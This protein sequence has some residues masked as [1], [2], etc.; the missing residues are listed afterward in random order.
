VVYPNPANDILNIKAD[1]KGAAS[2]QGTIYNNLGAVL[3]DLNF[4][5]INGV[6]TQQVAIGDLAPGMYVV[7]LQSEEGVATK[8]FVKK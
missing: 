2:V 8:H 5:S 4:T 6:Q 1:F 7:K 3:A